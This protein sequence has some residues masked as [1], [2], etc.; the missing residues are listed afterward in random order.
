MDLAGIITLLL[1]FALVGF[2]CYLIVTYIP[3]PPPFKQVIIVVM[4]IL[5]ILYLLGI[6]TG[7]ASAPVFNLRH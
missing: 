6:V 4:V 7:H 5:L 1:V 2:I 3:M